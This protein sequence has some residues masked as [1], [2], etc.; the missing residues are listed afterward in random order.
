MKNN[1]KKNTNNTIVQYLPLFVLLLHFHTVSHL[2]SPWML[3]AINASNRVDSFSSSA[4]W[5]PVDSQ[6][7]L[8]AEEAEEAKDIIIM[9]NL[10]S[11]HTTFTW[12]SQCDMGKW[13]K[14]SLVEGYR[15]MARMGW[16]TVTA[17]EEI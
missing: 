3:T 4:S 10:F 6:G 1:R 7:Q 11:P 16:I 17:Q 9:E 8:G 15:S 14:F 13:P 2:P 5:I 12:I